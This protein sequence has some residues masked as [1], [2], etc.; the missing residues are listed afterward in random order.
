M[1]NVARFSDFRQGE[2]LMPTT[3][4]EQ[5]RLVI[6]RDAVQA[7]AEWIFQHQKGHASARLSHLRDD[8]ERGV[9]LA[10]A[11]ELLSPERRTERQMRLNTLRHQGLAI[12]EDAAEVVAKKAREDIAIYGDLLLALFM[13]TNPRV[14]PLCRE[15]LI[16]NAA[17]VILTENIRGRAHG[18]C[19]AKQEDRFKFINEFTY[20][21]LP[22]VTRG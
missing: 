11:M 10:D 6:E 17:D 3:P 22:A 12:R 4:T 13:R 19:C 18:L 21:L 5:N 7:I 2:P 1:E 14:C 15:D 20:K 9:F 16:T 8:D